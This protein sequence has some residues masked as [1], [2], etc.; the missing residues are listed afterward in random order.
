MN[1]LSFENSF[2]S[3]KKSIYWSKKNK[4]QPYNVSKAT[5]KK[6]IFDCNICGHEFI[7]R[8]SNI[9]NNQWCPFCCK[10]KS[11]L[12]INIECEFCFKR[13]FAS[14]DK[15]KYWSSKN[16]IKPRDIN[17]S[18]G[19]KFIFNC[20]ICTH[21][22]I[23]QLVKITNNTWCPYCCDYNKKLCDNIQC[24][25][26]LNN[27]FLSSEKSKYWSSK[28]K[29]QPR[30][31]NILS[32]KKYIFNC[33]C[34]H[35]FLSQINSI[36]KGHW[37]PY[38]CNGGSQKL[39][40]NEL[41]I[42]CL[43]NSFANNEKSKYWS[44]K[45]TEKPR[46]VMNSTKNKYIFSCE[47]NHEFKKSLNHISSQKSWCPM[48]KHKTEKKLYDWLINKLSVN[49]IE[50]QFKINKYKYDFYI[51]DLNLIIELDGLQHF[52]QISNWKSP[53]SCLINDVKKI[54]LSIINK[55]K[56]IHITQEDVLYDKNNWNIILENIIK[57]IK[58][59]NHNVYFINTQNIYIK[60]IY[61]ILQNNNNNCILVI[62]P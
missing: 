30:N 9:H 35:E 18:S 13:S 38:C 42:M 37:C 62:Q 26:C 53:E 24:N 61:N 57:N 7:K 59:S 10:I 27:S 49:N 45:N 8:I 60:H 20:N 54:N 22:F 55:Y 34:G 36:Y 31:V 16:K 33:N 56:I 46:Q 32:G 28:N 39:C 19:K 6:F 17:I 5:N 58:N 44:Y 3:N 52:K 4:L 15:S 25:L 1:N 29:I 47:N 2:A 50:H 40:N 21:E 41:C 11:K 51:K 12:C 14:S 43:N 23:A 48:C